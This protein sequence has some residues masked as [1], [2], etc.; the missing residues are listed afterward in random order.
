MKNSKQ[1]G[2]A[3]SANN[4]PFHLNNGS[5][6][7][8]QHSYP[9]NQFNFDSAQ[10]FEL[11]LMDNESPERNQG[12]Y[13]GK[14]NHRQ[15]MNDAMFFRM[16][17]QD[18]SSNFN[19]NQ[20]FNDPIPDQEGFLKS[21]L[22]Q[23][24]DGDYSDRFN[25][26]VY[27]G[28]VGVGGVGGEDL[29]KIHQNFAGDTFSQISSTYEQQLQQVISGGNGNSNQQQSRHQQ[30]QNDAG[31]SNKLSNNKLHQYYEKNRSKSKQNNSNNINI[32]DD[33]LLD[34]AILNNLNEDMNS[35]RELNNNNMNHFSK[36]IP[37]NGNQIIDF[38][39]SKNNDNL[40]SPHSNLNN[41]IMNSDNLQQSDIQ[42]TMTI[43][44]SG[45]FDDASIIR[46]L[47]KS[48]SDDSLFLLQQIEDV[49]GNKQQSQMRTG[50]EIEN[51]F[52]FECE[53]V[54]Q[55]LMNITNK[56]KE[57][58]QRQ[59]QNGP[60]SSSQFVPI[61]CEELKSFE[62]LQTSAIEKIRQIQS[63]GKLVFD[64][65]RV[66]SLSFKN[67]KQNLK[68]QLHNQIQ[69]F[70]DI[71]KRQYQQAEERKFKYQINE[72]ENNEKIQQLEE[73]LE[74]QNE[75]V[76]KLANKCEQLKFEKKIIAQKN[77]QKL[78]EM[79]AIL[80]SLI[81]NLESQ[82][83]E[84]LSKINN[85]FCLGTDHS[86]LLQ[87]INK[88]RLQQIKQQQ[89][90][91]IQQ[92]VDEKEN[93]SILS[94]QV[95]SKYYDNREL[96]MNLQHIKRLVRENKKINLV[97]RD[98]HQFQQ[99]EGG[100]YYE[101]SSILNLMGE[102][103]KEN[104]Q[105]D[106]LIQ[107]SQFIPAEGSQ[108]DIN[109]AFIQSQNASSSMQSQNS[110]LF[111]RGQKMINIEEEDDN[112]QSL[113][114]K[115]DKDHIL[116]VMDGNK[117]HQNIQQK[118]K[119]SLKDIMY[120]DDK[121]SAQDLVAGASQEDI[122]DT[123]RRVKEQQRQI[124]L[125]MKKTDKFDQKFFS[126]S[127][128]NS[129]DDDLN[130]LND[131]SKEKLGNNLQD[132]NFPHDLSGINDDF[133]FKNSIQEGNKFGSG[134]D[135][136]I[137]DDFTGGSLE[138]N[139]RNDEKLYSGGSSQ[140]S[141]IQAFQSSKRFVNIGNNE[142]FI[143]KVLDRKI[144]IP[145]LNLR[146]ISEYGEPFKHNIPDIENS[147]ESSLSQ[148]Q[149]PHSSKSQVQKQIIQTDPPN[150]TS[151]QN[152]SISKNYQDQIENTYGS[153]K[154]DAGALDQ[155]IC[156]DNSKINNSQSSNKNS[157]VPQ[158]AGFNMFDSFKQELSRLDQ[159][160][161]NQN[162]N[163]AVSSGEKSQVNNIKKD[164]QNDTMN[165]DESLIQPNQDDNII[166]NEQFRQQFLN[167]QQKQDLIHGQSRDKSVDL[168][169]NLSRFKKS[170]SD[171]N[172]MFNEVESDEEE[173][174][175]KN[176]Y[177]KQSNNQPQRSTY[178]SL[179]NQDDLNNEKNST[180]VNLKKL[181]TPQNQAQ[182]RFKFNQPRDESLQDQKQ[183]QQ[184]QNG[185]KLLR[186]SLGQFQSKK[187]S[188]ANNSKND[189]ELSEKQSDQNTESQLSKPVRTVI[190]LNKQIIHTIQDQQIQSTEGSQK[191]QQFSGQRMTT[192]SPDLSE[193]TSENNQKIKRIVQ[194]PKNRRDI[195]VIKTNPNLEHI[196]ESDQN[197][198][199]DPYISD[200]SS[201]NNNKNIKS[202]L[203][204]NYVV[205][206]ASM[207]SQ[208]SHK[209]IQSK[210]LNQKQQ[211]QGT[212]NQLGF[213]QYSHQDINNSSNILKA[214]DP[215]VSNSNLIKQTKEI[216]NN[217]MIQQMKEYQEQCDVSLNVNIQ[218]KK[219]IKQ[220]IAPNNQTQEDEDKICL[221]PNQKKS[222]QSHTPQKKGLM[223]VS[224]QLI[225]AKI[226][227]NN[228]NSTNVTNIA[229]VNA[230]LLVEADN[231]GQDK[232]LQ[233]FKMPI[234]KISLN[235]I[236]MNKNGQNKT[237]INQSESVLIPDHNHV[238]N[239]M[240]IHDISMINPPPN[241][242]KPKPTT[243]LILNNDNNTSHIL[244]QSVVQG[245]KG[246]LP[247][248]IVNKNIQNLVSQQATSQSQQKQQQAFKQF[249][250]SKD[251]LDKIKKQQAKQ[252]ESS[253][254]TVNQSAIFQPLN[255]VNQKSF[256]SN[257]PKIDRSMLVGDQSAIIQNNMSLLYQNSNNPNVTQINNEYEGPYDM[258]MIA[259]SINDANRPSIIN[260]KNY[261][262]LP[263]KSKAN[264]NLFAG[265]IKKVEEN[266]IQKRRRDQLLFKASL[267]N[268]QNSSSSN[269]NQNQQ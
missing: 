170:Q 142:I 100:S 73:R 163:I 19:Q 72:F 266:K 148:S 186:K 122:S 195:S 43:Y 264:A 236:K 209:S 261:S 98:D 191:P 178:Q 12:A 223:I 166:F 104:G 24:L 189:P 117:N 62:I 246:V 247:S 161:G 59:R 63:L 114:Y 147:Q 238:E 91:D 153:M 53:D 214:A 66:K 188:S 152:E 199:K 8:S 105:R 201:V 109:R 48:I 197:S 90:T 241:S 128:Q 96:R 33:E 174:Q 237:V 151:F 135:I 44:N 97:A 14:Q 32:H 113:D 184:P 35:P 198:A 240:M 61:S 77:Q 239:S 256:K 88:K 124:M 70:K 216:S 242:Q 249:S 176:P 21:I 69:K 92:S 243:K 108:A 160:K 250:V 123:Q 187:R 115:F 260:D 112:N 179:L 50:Q 177:N 265:E 87:P 4:V 5:H 180:Q 150:I 149:F 15:N 2:V 132:L 20:F 13:N 106:S 193:A 171:P 230:S 213:A 226:K 30:S 74:R 80:K 203:I 245:Q 138:F 181:K 137:A 141:M 252:N 257:N 9:Y 58:L 42:S 22:E 215:Y 85:S 56:Y 159:V 233:K 51:S 263:S 11:A 111:I 165:L 95:A 134:R 225:K 139:S 40:P 78:I 251:L 81:K 31:K 248:S 52:K 194:K 99:Q 83:R 158:N 222:S 121:I 102:L 206:A 136:F 254:S 103:N 224:K 86:M 154:E 76:N 107:Q 41:I 183:N 65:Q 120:L 17:S 211:A 110:N 26:Q 145:K 204:Q 6:S 175:Q 118:S 67:Y 27:I 84:K 119:R 54:K 57:R 205:S 200:N 71:C 140:L 129:I 244:N 231:Q 127:Q 221:S 210:I 64:S 259:P 207:Q 219:M 47:D 131:L 89:M 93:E 75:D 29:N 101:S 94:N 60:Q 116:V 1:G 173:K 143:V 10:N 155:A 82:D 232:P 7:H 196:I 125:Q 133:Q 262:S 38:Q 182:A 34:S 37:G 18:Q 55:I 164:T 156:I 146:V 228:V 23:N 185:K 49:N 192:Q 208:N 258:S 220:P 190:S 126:M 202:K 268:Q 229:G 217:S 162:V 68:I 79:E 218:R 235:K 16:Q 25:R 169:I 46:I 172:L 130:I 267:I 157:F 144:H 168:S 3:S 253:V 269:I 28:G 255:I 234:N 167:E 45:I 227:I 39:Y 212:R 36:I